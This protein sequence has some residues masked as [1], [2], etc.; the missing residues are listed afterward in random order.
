MVERDVTRRP[1]RRSD[2]PADPATFA[3]PAGDATIEP[4]A[5]GGIAR[6]PTA[7]FDIGSIAIYPPEQPIGPEG[8]EVSPAIADRIRAQQGGGAPLEPTVQREMEAG[9]AHTFADVRLHTDGE[10]DTL[11]RSVGARAFTLGSDIFLS[12]GATD[13]GAKSG[14]QLLAHELTH[15]VQQRGAQQ[16][17]SLTV[18]PVGDATEREAE[19][20]AAAVAEGGVI[21]GRLAGTRRGATI[22]RDPETGAKPLPT[23]EEMFANYNMAKNSSAGDAANGGLTSTITSVLDAFSAP[24]SPSSPS[25]APKSSV[26]TWWHV[27]DHM[28]TDTMSDLSPP[29]IIK[30]GEPV[31]VEAQL[32]GPPYPENTLI[33]GMDVRPREGGAAANVSVTGSR[34]DERTYRW[35][36]TAT[37]PGNFELHFN[38]APD[39]WVGSSPYS[40]GEGYHNLLAYADAT[41]FKGRCSTAESTL[42][43]LY[44]KGQAWFYECYMNYMDAYAAFNAS[45]T[46]Q[47]N[48]EKLVGDLLLGALFAV[49]GGA[50]GGALGG[51]MKDA[52]AAGG[53]LHKVFTNVQSG[54]LTDSAKDL[55][56]YLV[57]LPVGPLKDKVLG[58]HGGGAHASGVEASTDASKA[59]VAQG[60]G[61]VAAIDPEHWYAAIERTINTERGEVGAMLTSLQEGL[62]T[63]LVT[64]PHQS[65]DWDPVQVITEAAKLDG[66]PLDQLGTA[67]PALAY[68]RS[69]WEV[70]LENYSWTIG[71]S[72]GFAIA[73]SNVGGKLKDEIDRV[74]EKF[75]ETGDQWIERYGK[76]LK[77]KVEAE[78]ADMPSSNVMPI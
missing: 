74:A 31:I 46:K 4:S 77:G 10:A 27:T 1:R 39:P 54:V 63:I 16:R 44:A 24:T 41:W 14:D 69:M 58:S 29:S 35:V 42:N 40:A 76:Q 65:F 71:S 51:M 73:E 6:A 9:F 57:R 64:D 13:R 28:G 61:N 22:Q 67:P 33:T 8:G 30:L 68:E 36:V 26:A 17:G 48:A 45:L 25:A 75:G 60:A 59:G 5:D 12:R 43:T 11:N 52:E 50:I 66:K 49:G 56:K 23:L 19:G 34:P 37:G 7:G 70:W 55:A 2:P 20:A 78:A 47:R 38:I 53:I 18:G 21:A 62:D 32:A 15:V 3:T 72:G